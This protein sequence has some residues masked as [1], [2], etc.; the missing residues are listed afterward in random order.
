M[1]TLHFRLLVLR[2]VRDGLHKLSPRISLLDRCA[3]IVYFHDLRKQPT[4]YPTVSIS[5]F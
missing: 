5:Q 4:E 1:Y 3:A 2:E